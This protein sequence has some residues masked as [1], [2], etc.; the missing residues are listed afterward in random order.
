MEGPAG[1]LYAL[2]AVTL[3]WDRRNLLQ[4]SWRAAAKGEIVICDRYPSNII[5]AM[6]SPRLKEKAESRGWVTSIYNK[7]ARLERN[8]Y[9]QIPPPDVVLR[10]RVSVK[11]A[12]ERNRLRNKPGGESDNYI[13]IRH[14]HASEWQRTDTRR[15]FDVD[16]ER[17]LTETM[18]EIKDIIW[19]SL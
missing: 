12:I 10:L 1:L 5:G 19:H 2:R 13:E 18:F 14:Q 3:A 4:K 15:V 16:T 9:T 8:L 6:D 7:A 17:P 11:T